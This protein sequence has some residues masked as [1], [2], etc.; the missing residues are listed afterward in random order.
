MKKKPYI[1]PAIVQIEVATGRLLSESLG[2]STTTVTNDNQVFAPE[3]SGSS[4]E[5]W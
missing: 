3:S 2:I 1:A 4:D 5:A